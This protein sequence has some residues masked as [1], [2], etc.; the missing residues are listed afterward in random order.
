MTYS[1]TLLASGSTRLWLGLFFLFIV[2][3]TKHCHISSCDTAAVPHEA[4]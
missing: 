1:V 2:T 3:A 4:Q